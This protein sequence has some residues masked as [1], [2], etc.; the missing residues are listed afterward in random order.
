VEKLKEN[1]ESLTEGLMSIIY[2][3][4]M[5]GKKDALINAFDHNPTVK[6]DLEDVDQAL[7][8]LKKSIAAFDKLKKS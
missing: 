6:K 4:L 3:K 8:K 1:K 2:N 7:S 5:K